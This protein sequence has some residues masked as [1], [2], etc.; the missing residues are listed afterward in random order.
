MGPILPLDRLLP[1][2][3]RPSASPGNGRR[4]FLLPPEPCGETY[5]SPRL[6]T[7]QVELHPNCGVISLGLTSDSATF[8]L[9]DLK[10]VPLLSASLLISKC[11][12]QLSHLG[13]DVSFNTTLSGN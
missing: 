8:W 9:C 6:C 3:R 1:S 13:G 7:T 12:K 4:D 2:V 11:E 5:L 10:Q